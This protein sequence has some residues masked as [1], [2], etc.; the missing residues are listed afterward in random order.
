MLRLAVAARYLSMSPGKLRAK[1]Q[2]GELAVIRGGDG[3]SPWL[4]DKVEIDLWIERQKQQVM[5]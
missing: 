3:N 2:A 5:P 4:L 1:I